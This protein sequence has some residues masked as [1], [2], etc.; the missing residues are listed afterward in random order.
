[1]DATDR[2]HGVLCIESVNIAVRMTAA[3]AR[4]LYKLERTKVRRVFWM[5]KP[6]PSMLLRLSGCRYTRNCG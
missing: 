5:A 4:L 3:I 6:K 1:M 2:R